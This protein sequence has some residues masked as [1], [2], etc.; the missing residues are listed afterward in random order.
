MK[1]TIR[2][3]QKNQKSN[4][5]KYKI[6]LLNRST[7]LTAKLKEQIILLV[8]QNLC[9]Q[10]QRW[11]TNQKTFTL[12]PVVQSKTITRT[13]IN[14]ILQLFEER[15]CENTMTIFNLENL[16]TLTSLSNKCSSQV[17]L[18]NRNLQT[19][20]ENKNVKR[21][22]KRKVEIKMLF[23]SQILIQVQQ[24][25]LKLCLKVFRKRRQRKRRKQV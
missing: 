24:K 5:K 14:G 3:K 7:K 17:H 16:A 18:K 15:F 2:L 12:T 13:S 10:V 22:T 19:Q 4:N 6:Q 11:S 9:V 21:K 8:K 23:R 25:T 1:L 20:K